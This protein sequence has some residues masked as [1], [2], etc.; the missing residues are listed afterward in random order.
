MAVWAALCPQ[1]VSHTNNFWFISFL[2]SN[3]AIRV[4]DIIAAPNPQRTE[5]AGRAPLSTD[6]GIIYSVSLVRVSDGG[7]WL[8]E[9]PYVPNKSLTPITLD[10]YPFF[11][12]TRPSGSQVLPQTRKE[13]RQQWEIHLEL[14]QVKCESCK[15]VRWRWMAVWT[16]Q[17]LLSEFIILYT[18]FY[19]EEF[20]ILKV[21]FVFMQV[22][23]VF[24]ACLMSTS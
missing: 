14:I 20:I 24:T 19:Y 12:Q 13:Q 4:T 21:Y 3:Q 17:V 11:H 10:L 23:F 8:S 2:P 1:Q 6:S 9:L 15:G 18:S 7:G 16:V 5:A 22:F